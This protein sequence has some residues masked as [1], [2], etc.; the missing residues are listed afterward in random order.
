[1]WEGIV[2]AQVLV[3]CGG[4]DTKQN[5]ELSFVKFTAFKQI[6]LRFVDISQIYRYTDN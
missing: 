1:M 2:L 4:D 5:G 6:T 3:S